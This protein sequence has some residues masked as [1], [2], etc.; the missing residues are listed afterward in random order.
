MLGIPRTT[1]TKEIKDAYRRCALE[2]HPDTSAL[3]REEARRR[4]AQLQASYEAVTAPKSRGA[5]GTRDSRG[6]GASQASTGT[7]GGAFGSAS[8]WP[9]VDRWREN[10]EQ[11]ARRAGTGFH[12]GHAP[13]RGVGTPYAPA[14]VLFATVT[15]FVLALGVNTMR[16]HYARAKAVSPSFPL[17]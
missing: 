15:T 3:P 7:G 5:R 6:R 12:H 11:R 8:Q 10:E 4:F 9:H 14:L 17:P 16:K 1:N 13:K 2:F